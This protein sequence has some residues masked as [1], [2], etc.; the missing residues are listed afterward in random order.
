MA[1]APSGFR[2]VR[3]YAPVEPRRVALELLDHGEQV[4]RHSRRLRALRVRVHRENRLAVRSAR[5]SSDRAQVERSPQQVEDQLAL[6]HPVHRHVDVVAAARRVQP[7]G[8]ILAAAIRDQAIHVEEQVLALAVE[9]SRRTASC[10]TASSASRIAWASSGE[11]IPC[12][13]SITRCA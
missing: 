10:E 1:H 11:T 4:V 9:R 5:S 12:A 8:D 7:S 13:A 3:S 6:P 2:L